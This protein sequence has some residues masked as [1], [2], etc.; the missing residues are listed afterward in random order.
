[1]SDKMEV[2]VAP[3]TFALAA[4]DTV[5]ATTTIRNLGQ[6]VDQLTLNIDGLDPSWYTLP[7]SSVALF[8][9]DQDNLKII[10]HPPKIPETKSGFYYL[11]VIVVSQEN[12]D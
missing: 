12:P 7:V 4:G 1:M 6:S 2:T 9:N 5:E 3:T 11:H 10:L 8:P